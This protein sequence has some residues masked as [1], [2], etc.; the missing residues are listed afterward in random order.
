[1]LLNKW[2]FLTVQITAGVGEV[3][4]HTGRFLKGNL[5]KS[6]GF[7]YVLA[8]AIAIASFIALKLDVNG[9]LEYL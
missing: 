8:I 1:M 3:K 7:D 6:N 9:S 4:F 2:I 5:Q